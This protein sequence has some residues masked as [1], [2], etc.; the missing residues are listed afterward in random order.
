MKIAIIHSGDVGFVARL[1]NVFLGEGYDIETFEPTRRNLL[2]TIERI[3]DFD[4]DVVILDH[5]FDGMTGDDIVVTSLSYPQDICI[6]F[7]N[8]PSQK[9]YCSNIID[10]SLNLE[11]QKIREKILKLV[12]RAASV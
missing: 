9:D 4:P 6:G 3:S 10:P 5:E 2:D 11:D 12:E 7:S 8:D 1:M